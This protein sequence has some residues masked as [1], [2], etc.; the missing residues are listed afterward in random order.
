MRLADVL[1]TDSETMNAGLEFELTPLTSI[2]FNVERTEDRFPRSPSRN[3]ETRRVGATVTFQPGALISGRAATR[4]PRL[5]AA[6]LRH[7][8]R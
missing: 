2:S 1:N 4:V 6:K 8:A 5:R 3:A 7:S